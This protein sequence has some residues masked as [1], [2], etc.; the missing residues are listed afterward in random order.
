MEL[1]WLPIRYRIL[2]RLALLMHMAH[3]NKSPAYIGDVT[4][5]VSRDLSRSRLPQSA[6]NAGPVL[7]RRWQPLWHR[8]GMPVLDQR[9]ND[10][11]SSAGPTPPGLCRH[12]VTHPASL[13]CAYIAYINMAGSDGVWGEPIGTPQKNIGG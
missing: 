7:A 11:R 5:P 6:Y 10:Y 9:R 1:H 2:F 8:T 3:N 13:N 4:L 12:A